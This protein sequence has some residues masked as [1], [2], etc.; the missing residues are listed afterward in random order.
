L[1]NTNRERMLFKVMQ[2]ASQSGLEAASISDS[3]HDF[4][5]EVSENATLPNLQIIHQ[6]IDTAFVLI[7]GLINIPEMDRRKLKNFNKNKFDELIWN[8]KLNL[9]HAGIDFTVLGS[10][11]DPDAWEVQKHLFLN[12]ASINQFYEAYSRVKNSLIGIIWSYKQALD[13]SMARKGYL[14]TE[15]QVTISKAEAVQSNTNR[16]QKIMNVMINTSIILMSTLM[17]GFTQA[18]METTD[19]MA[20]EMVRAMGGEEAREEIDMEFHENLPEVDEK[21]KAMISDVRNDVSDQFTQKRGEIEPFL[22]DEAFDLGPK[23]VDG[24]DFQLPK[25]T[26]ELDDG[27]FMQYARLL[28]N[29]DPLFSEMFN[30][31]TN[32]MN[33]LPKFP[34]KVDEE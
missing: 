34:D 14:E 28:V 3:Q 8:I 9:L 30:E 23:I 29:E 15:T 13:C 20:S 26:E 18:M 12:E 4:V 32:W 25:L 16:A 7:V 17:D 24:Y 5:V 27:T 10:E 1:P 6:E 2:W 21:M 22:T 33:N 11:K 19:A 31:L